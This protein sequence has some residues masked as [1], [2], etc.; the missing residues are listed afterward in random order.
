LRKYITVTKKRGDVDGY[1]ST[2]LYIIG[3]T[4]AASLLTVTDKWRAHLPLFPL[5]ACCLF[6]CALHPNVPIPHTTRAYIR[7]RKRKRATIQIWGKE[8][9]EENRKR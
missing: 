8:R 1:S 2:V 4:R 5:W 3:L 6:G 9:V 7:E